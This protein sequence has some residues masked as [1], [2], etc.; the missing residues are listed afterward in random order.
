M[1]FV[2]VTAGNETR[3]LQVEEGI[4]FEGLKQSIASVFP[5]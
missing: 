2:K 5:V 1:V 4:T 3:K